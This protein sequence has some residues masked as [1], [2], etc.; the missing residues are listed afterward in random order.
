MPSV[1]DINTLKNNIRKQK[2]LFAQ[3]RSRDRQ[4]YAKRKDYHISH[5]IIGSGGIFSRNNATVEP[6][7]QRQA[8]VDWPAMTT[9]AFNRYE[10]LRRARN[11]SS[12]EGI[13]LY[14][15]FK[16]LVDNG[17]GARANPHARFGTNV[18][19]YYRLMRAKVT[20]LLAMQRDLDGANLHPLYP[21][22]IEQIG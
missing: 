21:S 7:R 6:A 1:E 11:L 13:Q 12:N 16:L 19:T 17:Q 14:R 20:P 2:L 5:H 9:Q 22:I 10:Q 4:L 3:N 18:N 8:F 15:T